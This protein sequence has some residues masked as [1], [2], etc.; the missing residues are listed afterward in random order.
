MLKPLRAEVSVPSLTF[1]FLGSNMQT[2]WACAPA[3]TPHK[4]FL[5][6]F[7]YLDL[8]TPIGISRLIF[9]VQEGYQEQGE[10]VDQTQTYRHVRFMAPQTTGQACY[11]VPH[12]ENLQ[13]GGKICYQEITSAS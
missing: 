7:P 6:A 4:Y 8:Q 12:A 9:K 1:P 11:H 5:L 2:H 10:P 3:S 13:Y